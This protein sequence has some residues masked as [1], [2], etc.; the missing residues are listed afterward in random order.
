MV[1]PQLKAD[2][3]VPV[4]VKDK[5]GNDVQQTEIVGEGDNAVEVPVYKKEIRN[6]PASS[7]HAGVMAKVHS[8]KGFWWSNSKQPL[9]GIVG[10]SR[11]IDYQIHDPNSAAN[12]LNKGHVTTTISQNGFRVWGNR[13][14]TKGAEKFKSVVITN[15]VIADSITKAHQWALDRNITKT[16]VEDVTENVNTFLRRLTV[17]GTIEVGRCLADPELNTADSISEGQ[18]CFDY[19]FSC[20]SPAEQITFQSRMTK[21]YLKEII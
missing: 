3:D 1:A 16:Y 2:I 4:M 11:P 14:I 6:V 18:I 17:M 12:T 5:D 20:F 8:E 13:T 7:F 19:E 21:K 15:D 10:L 9:R